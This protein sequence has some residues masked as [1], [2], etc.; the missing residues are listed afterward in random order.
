MNSALLRYALLCTASLTLSAAMRGQC[1][2]TVY[3]SGGAGGAYAN[4]QNLTWTYCAPAGQ[5]VTINFTQFNTEAGYDELS[6]HDGPTNASPTLGIFSGTALPPSFT[7]SVPGGCITLWFTSD[8]SITYPGWAASITCGAPP[9]PV[10]VCGSTVYDQGGS[11]GDYGN[12]ANTITTYCPSTAGDVVTMNFSQ[13]NTEA[14]YDFVTIYN[15]PNTGAPSMGTYSGTGIPGPFTSTHPSGCITLAF[16]SDGTVTY[17]GWTATIACG[18]PPPPPSGDCVYALNLYDSFGDGWGTSNV[19]ISIN[20]APYTYYTVTALFNQVLIGVNIG[21][22]VVLSY[23]NSGAFQGENR[24]T[25]GLQG[26]GVY[27]N[28]G[29]PPTG[30]I[31]FTQTVNCQQPPAAPQDCVGGTTICSGQAFNNNSSNTGDVVDL[32]FS[33]QGCLSSAERQGTWYYFSPSASG[34]IGFTIAPAA[35]TDYDFAVWGPMSSVSCPPAGPPLR[36]SYAAPTGDT[37]AGNGATDPSEGAGGDRWVAPM[38][39][40]A[41]EVYIMYID[42]FSTNGQS[43]TLSWQLTNGASLD[44][45]VLPIGE[46]LLKAEPVALGAEVSWTTTFERGSS[47]FIVE[48]SVDGFSFSDVGTRNAAGHADAPTGYSF[49]D[50]DAIAGLNYYRIRSISLDGTVQY[51]QVVSVVLTHG[52]DFVVA[53]NPVSDGASLLLKV[54]VAGRITIRTMDTSGRLVHEQVAA[55]EESDQR[56]D[57]HW[58]VLDAGAYVLLVLDSSGDPIARV[59][60]ARQ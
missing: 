23:N 6:I 4:N 58:P 53:P 60:F 22:V 41:G 48:R 34:T 20:G 19:G 56:L 12:N 44:C 7:G 43:F 45:T 30:G 59:P 52:N 1:G 55:M 18:T 42:N 49:T 38:N 11:G 51:S 9:P 54:P 40:I 16:T 15:G 32:N 25:L 37:G 35:P 47:H 31:S 17:P 13:F 26:G 29:S 5:V 36:C 8:G 2:T 24:Y 3:D 28:S 50:N 27:F 10:P 57:L 21:D 46:V 14:G 33:N 39:V